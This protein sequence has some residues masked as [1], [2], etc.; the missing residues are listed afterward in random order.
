MKK[1]S[2]ESD[3]NWAREQ[4]KELCIKL[5]AILDDYKDK[6]LINEEQYYKHT[7]IKEGISPIL[8]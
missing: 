3:I 5:I 7:Y 8:L 6:G 2:I 4:L 1:H